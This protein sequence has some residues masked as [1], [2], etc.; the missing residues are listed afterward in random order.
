MF[1][2]PARRA[3]FERSKPLAFKEFLFT[4][5]PQKSF[6]ALIAFQQFR[7]FFFD[8]KLLLDIFFRNKRC[9]IIILAGFQAF[10]DEI[11]VASLLMI[12]PALC[13]PYCGRI[14]IDFSGVDKT[15]PY[16]GCLLMISA[17]Q[18]GEISK[19]LY[20]MNCFRFYETTCPFLMTSSNRKSPC[21]ERL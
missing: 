21:L 14:A 13:W 8:L 5:I 20:L 6:A 7:P 10:S 19:S 2:L 3:S 11:C 16:C 9:P 4:D 12:I 1:F 17:L 15:T 18:K